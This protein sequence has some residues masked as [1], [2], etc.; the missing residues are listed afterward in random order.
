MDSAKEER[1]N[2]IE[3]ILG[4]KGKVYVSGVSFTNPDGKPSDK[5]IFKDLSDLGYVF[6][7]SKT[8][9]SYKVRV[10][11]HLGGSKNA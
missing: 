7:I 9:S 6:H 8:K 11:Y 2:E 10:D 3:R 1:L 4:K 5:A